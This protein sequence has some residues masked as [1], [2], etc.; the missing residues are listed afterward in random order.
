[1]E[2]ALLPNVPEEHRTSMREG[3]GLVY[4]LCVATTA[5]KAVSHSL[6]KACYVQC[7]ELALLPI[8]PE[9]HRTSM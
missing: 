4:K 2:V 7:N 9:E 5:F 8:L 1:M 3:V 6:N